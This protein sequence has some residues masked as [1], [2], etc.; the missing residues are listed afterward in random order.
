[1]S[2]TRENQDFLSAVEAAIDDFHMLD[3][4]ETVLVGVSGGPDSVALLHSLVALAP[5]WSLRLVI[6]HLNH[7]L[8]GVTADHEAA[9]V[10]RLS[11]S[12][13]IPCE[14]GSRNVALY[15]TNHKLSLQE[16]ARIVRYTFFDEVA[17]KY[18]ASKIALGHHADDNA[19]SIL[20]HL[21]RGTGPLG[22]AGIPPVRHGHIIRPLIALTRKRVL[23]FLELNGFEYVRDG[24]NLDTKYLRNRIRHEL[25]PHLTGLYNR[26]TVCALNRLASILRDEE[27]FWDQ[28]VGR[29]FRDLVLEHTPDRLSLMARGLYDLHPALL[30]RVIRHA[31]LSLKGGLRRLGHIHVEA[32]AR[33]I[34][35]PSPSGR[36]DLPLGLRVIR[37]RE[38]V[39]FLSDLPEQIVVFE[40][41]IPRIQTTFIREIG[42]FMEL[43]V[44]DSSD[45]SHP[46]GYPL[47]TAFLDLNAVRFPLKV[48]NFRYGDRFRPLGM[49]GSQKVKTFFINQKVPRSKRPRCPILLSGEK[50][51]WVGGYRIDDSAKVTEKTKKVLKAELLPA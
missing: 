17:A 34:A 27:D 32:V 50:I 37:D 30:R 24:S 19:E 43:S 45:V 44:W 13:R 16:A 48:R 31:V 47:S 42:I 9:F 35:A 15:G 3:G 28:E 1:M 40:Y 29:A 25:L 38:E 2:T 41:H 8:R 23:H 46:K 18:S 4:G 7:Q 5:K 10:R 6:A 26:N 20:M 21:L 14:I 39:N 49:A 36:L 11:A 33:L 12:L 51:V 22:L